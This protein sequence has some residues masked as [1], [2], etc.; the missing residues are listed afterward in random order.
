MTHVAVAFVL[1]DKIC[2]SHYLIE[3][4]LPMTENQFLDSKPLAD[5]FILPEI[6]HC[7]ELVLIVMKMENVFH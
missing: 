4:R 5:Y 3:K 1:Q 2:S 7:D 6:L